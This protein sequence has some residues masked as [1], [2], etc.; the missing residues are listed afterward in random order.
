MRMSRSAG[1]LI[2]LVSILL[3]VPAYGQ[4][5]QLKKKTKKTV[6]QSV[7]PLKMEFEVTKVKYDPLKSPDKLGVKMVFKGHNPNGL[8]IKLNRTEFDLYIDDKFAA[9]MY[10][11]KK[12]E[13]PKNGE[14]SFD[15]KASIKIS[16]VG[17]TVF[18]AIRDDKVTYRIE[19]TYFVHS[20]VGEFSFKAKLVEKEL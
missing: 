5:N 15:E 11:E 14:F 13:I 8:G 4:M 9:K 20:P 1:A 17:K 12:I 18:K 6:K 7:K 16:T 19:G 10:N 3:C 2:V